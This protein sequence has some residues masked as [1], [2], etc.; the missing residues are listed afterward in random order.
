MY[1]CKGPNNLTFDICTFSE[2][3]T[4]RGNKTNTA[5]GGEINIIVVLYQ[6]TWGR[7]NNNRA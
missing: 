6:R 4:Y 2:N 7:G 5:I 1:F 3:Y